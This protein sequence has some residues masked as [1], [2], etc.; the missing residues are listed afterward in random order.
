MRTLDQTTLPT[1]DA[2]NGII[3]DF[4]PAFIFLIGTAGGHSGRDNLKLGDVVVANYVDFADYLKYTDQKVLKRKLAVDHPSFFLLERFV[5]PLR[6]EPTR[7]NKEIS[8][9]PKERKKGE[10]KLLT[11][12]IVSAN[13]LLGDPE[14]PE[15]KKILDMFDKALAFEMESMG[16]ARAVYTQRQ[17]IHYNPQYLVVRGISDYVDKHARQNQRKRKEWTPYAVKC[18]TSVAYEVIT[19]LLKFTSSV[20]VNP[21]KTRKA[22]RSKSR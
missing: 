19:D 1:Q 14:R 9:R 2:V 13:G 3:E 17:S 15:Q 5:E 18:A 7:W 10:S 16:V 22:A 12:E 21:R 20:R 6:A 4:R 8:G 11:G